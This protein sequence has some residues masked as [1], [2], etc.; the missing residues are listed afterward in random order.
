MTKRCSHSSL[1][2]SF[3]FL[4]I[5]NSALHQVTI[6]LQKGYAEKKSPL[7]VKYQRGTGK[8]FPLAESPSQRRLQYGP[9]RCPTPPLRS[10]SPAWLLRPGAPRARSPGEGAE[11]A[12]ALGRRGAVKAK[13]RIE[14]AGPRRGEHAALGQ[15]RERTRGSGRDVKVPDAGQLRASCVGWRPRR[16]LQP[17]TVHRAAPRLEGCRAGG[18]RERGRPPGRAETAG[19]CSRR[20]GQR[21]RCTRAAGCFPFS[22]HHLQSPCSR[23]VRKSTVSVTHRMS[24][25]L[26]T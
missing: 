5:K 9:R 20:G 13:A 19:S 12:G 17:G 10:D 3:T 7:P 4:I 26:P 23:D 16:H 8:D 14:R 18:R 25:R 22:S 24:L 2:P 11:G 21:E 15:M 1:K 6:P